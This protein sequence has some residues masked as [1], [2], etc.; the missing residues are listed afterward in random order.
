MLKSFVWNNELTDWWRYVS[1]NFGLLTMQ[2]LSCPLRTILSHRGPNHFGR[3]R[4]SR[5][6]HTRVSQAVESVKD[7]SSERE[8]DVGASGT[9][10]YVDEYVAASDVDTLEVQSGPRVP[11]EPF[12][13]GVEWLKTGYFIPIYAQVANGVDD[14]L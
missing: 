9:V 1:R 8:G 13:L 12:K 5:P 10:R 6:L 7:S 3:D 11:S 2:A 4:L 14:A